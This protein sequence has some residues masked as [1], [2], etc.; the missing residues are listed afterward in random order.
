MKATHGDLQEQVEWQASF[1]N[2]SVGLMGTKLNHGD[3]CVKE[4]SQPETTQPLI[5]PFS[6]PV[7][8]K[9]QGQRSE[10]RKSKE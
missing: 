9:P 4:A 10:G 5:Q 3:I 6:W 1:L 2:L 8:T 7:K